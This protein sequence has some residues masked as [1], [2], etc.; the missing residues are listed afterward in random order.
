MGGFACRKVRQVVENATRVLGIELLAACQALDL[1]MAGK[2]SP[3]TQAVYDL[4]RASVPP[5]GEDRVL[6]GELNHGYRLI[7]GGHVQRAA[8]VV[9]GEFCH[10]TP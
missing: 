5:L 6:Y 7:N 2:L 4:V 10:L 1:Q 8:E 9:I 3:A